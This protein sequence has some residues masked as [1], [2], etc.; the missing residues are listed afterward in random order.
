M[1]AQNF[2]PKPKAAFENSLPNV[3][4]ISSVANQQQKQTRSVMKV[5]VRINVIPPSD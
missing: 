5:K 4:F 2:L 3:V 1:P